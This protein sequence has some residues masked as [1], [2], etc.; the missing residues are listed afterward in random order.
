MTTVKKNI[1][2]FC[3]QNKQLCCIELDLLIMKLRARYCLKSREE[4]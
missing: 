3:V 1:M 4:K 2:V